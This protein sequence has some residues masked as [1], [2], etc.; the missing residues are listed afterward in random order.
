MLSVNGRSSGSVTCKVTCRYKVAIVEECLKRLHSVKGRKVTNLVRAKRRFNMV[1]RLI[2]NKY[3]MD[4]FRYLSSLP[5]AIGPP[6][7]AVQTFDLSLRSDCSSGSISDQYRWIIHLARSHLDL[8]SFGRV[9]CHLA[10]LCLNPRSRHRRPGNF[11][12]SPPLF[13]A[14]ERVKAEA[15]PERL[16]LL[17]P[18]G[19]APRYYSR[20]EIYRSPEEASRFHVEICK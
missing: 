5:P 10:G 6:S 8:L 9:P 2:A 1:V 13:T 20:M 14:V 17:R 7:S 11:S 19:R 18:A 15:T 3:Y 16:S 4:S 12:R